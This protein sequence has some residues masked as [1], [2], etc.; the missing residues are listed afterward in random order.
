MVNDPSWKWEMENPG[1][2]P[3]G[4][5]KGSWAA[6]RKRLFKIIEDLVQWENMTNEEILEQARVEI[7]RSWRDVCALN[8]DHP[9]A[10]E[11]FDPDKLPSLHDP[12]CGGG[13]IPLEAQRLGLEAYGS[14]LNPVAVL[15]TKA[16]IEIPPKFA[17]RAPVGPLL[18]DQRGG[19]SRF[20][21]RMARCDR[22][23]GRCPSVWIMD[24]RGSQ[25]THWVFVSPNRAYGGDD[26]GA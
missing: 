4:H 16:M 20:A 10:K 19:T 26:S 6:S 21:Q 11:L 24:R 12:F 9:R 17:R 7:R 5:P 18:R 8:K 2:V 25:K 1:K 13:A 14:D 23:C 3:P 22:A 15:I